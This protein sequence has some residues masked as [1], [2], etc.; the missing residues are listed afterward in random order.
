MHEWSAE[1]AVEEALA[2]RLLASQF[3]ELE[4]GSVR[5]LGE[6][7]DNSVWLVDEGWAFRFPHRLIAV[8][9]VERELALLPLLGPLLPLPI[10]VPVFVGRPEGVY[11]WPFFGGPLVP[12]REAADADLDDEARGRCAR[13][14]AEFL[15]TLHA[16][17]S[18]TAV[19]TS[20]ELQADPLRRADMSF[21]VPMAETRFA[22]L[23]RLGL[24]RRSVRVDAIL[25]AALTLPP[26]EPSAVVHGDLHL[27]HLL[28][29]ESGAPSGV[30][31]WGD[32]C[33]ADPAIDLVL[34]W[35]LL[36]PVARGEFLAAYGPVGEEALLRARV[37]SL[38]LCGALAVHAHH[39][40]FER[41][42]RETLAGLERTLA[43]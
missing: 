24:R 3:P 4:L 34:F 40:G 35:C 30:I 38:F 26:T 6:G 9:G 36:P 42:E 43:D 15:R 8:P 32:A 18:L 10:P 41:I 33:F 12:G 22:E 17:E 13:P 16:P 29:D 1:I 31:D 2:R 20:V 7:W 14:L 23:E 39:E 28:V 19:S 25:R 37:L 5:R 21:R 27:R 11:P